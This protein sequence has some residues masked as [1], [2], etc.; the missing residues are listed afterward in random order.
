MCNYMSLKR[1]EGYQKVK[2]T[3]LLSLG[4]EIVDDLTFFLYLFVFV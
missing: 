1:P 3:K 4:D 2:V